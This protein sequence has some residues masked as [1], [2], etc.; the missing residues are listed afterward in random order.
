MPWNHMQIEF[1]AD[2][3]QFRPMIGPGGQTREQAH[4]EIQGLL[5]RVPQLAMVAATWR[6]GAKDDTVYAGDLIWCI[7]EHP[8]GEDPRKAAIVWM[9]DLAVTMRAAGVDVQVAKFPM[10]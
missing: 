10:P 2:D 7:Y 3:H 6:R 4:K 1:V 8:A 5:D 9:E